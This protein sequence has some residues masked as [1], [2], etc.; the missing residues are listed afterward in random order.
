MGFST[1][2]PM[3]RWCSQSMRWGGSHTTTK[4][5]PPYAP[6][7]HRARRHK[8]VQANQR[9]C[10]PDG[11]VLTTGTKTI[12][13]DSGQSPNQP[14]GQAWPVCPPDGLRY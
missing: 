6:K 5:L 2:L 9:V 1:W 14:P 4:S 11:G 8:I 13:L 10:E 12:A 3:E 7:A